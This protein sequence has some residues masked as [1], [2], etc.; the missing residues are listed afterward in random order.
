MT[1]NRHNIITKKQGDYWVSLIPFFNV[2][3]YGVTK[4]ES[5]NDL[6]YNIAIL[7]DDL[8]KLSET[9]THTNN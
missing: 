9:I 6:K 7:R 2:S 5:L 3:G 8:L 4:A 1:V